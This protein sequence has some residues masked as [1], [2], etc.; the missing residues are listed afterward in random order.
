MPTSSPLR[1]RV[2]QQREQILDIAARYGATNVRLFGSVAR[3]DAHPGSDIDFLVDLTRAWSLFDH[4]GMQQDLED[5]L[6]CKVD[7][8]VASSLKEHVRTGALTE[9]LLV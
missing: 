2:D 7:L 8:I 4:I 1:E 5:L 9:S 6:G 3:G